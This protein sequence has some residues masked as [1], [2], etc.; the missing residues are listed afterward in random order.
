MDDSA[1]LTA[2]DIAAFPGPIS[3]ISE[4]AAEDAGRH[5]R[6]A[7]DVTG[8][9]LWWDAL[10]IHHSPFERNALIVPMFGGV[11]EYRAICIVL[12]FSRAPENPAS[13]I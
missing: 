8:K 7:V 1:R 11:G 4:V 13:R 9:D 3:Q 5:F 6:V 10:P 2:E 12:L